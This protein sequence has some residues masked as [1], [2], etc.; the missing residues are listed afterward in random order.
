MINDLPVLLFLDITSTNL[1]EWNV[2]E[3]ALIYKY[4]SFIDTYL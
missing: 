4:I 3:D 1:G 2:H